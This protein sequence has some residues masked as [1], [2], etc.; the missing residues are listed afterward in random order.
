MRKI[1]A[2]LGRETA[3]RLNV[4]S[5]NERVYINTLKEEDVFEKYKSCFEGLGKLKDFQLNIPVDQNVK[6]VVQSG[7]L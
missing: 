5:L 7:L 6:P 1:E 2:L 4:L 3:T